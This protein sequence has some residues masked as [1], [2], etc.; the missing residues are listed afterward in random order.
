[1]T[2]KRFMADVVYLL[3][4]G[5]TLGGVLVLGIFT[6][7]VIFHGS[8]LEHYDAGVVMAEIFRRFTY[9]LYA[10][11]FAIVIY[12]GFQYKQFKR[13]RVAIGA[14]LMSLFSILLFNGVYTPK[15]LEMQQQ[16]AQMT[17][18]EAFANLHTASEIDFKLLALALVVLFVRRYYLI[19]HPQR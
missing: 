9:W 17:Q 4:L 14:T 13:D 7:P 10:A 15:I 16:G 6:A 12:E 3:M 18:S 2:N 11:L 8:G 1:M 19:T 5:M